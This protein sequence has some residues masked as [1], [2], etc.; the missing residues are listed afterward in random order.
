MKRD[1]NQRLAFVALIAAVGF[2]RA[3]VL[4]GAD[5][6]DYARDIKPLLVQHCAKCHGPA[7]REN[8][9]RLD[10][11][12]A[13]M[14]G[15]D[16]GAAIVPGKGTESLLVR[17]LLG[18]EENVSKMP[19]E[20]PGLSPEQIDLITRWIDAGANAPADEQPLPAPGSQHW[21]FQPPVRLAPPAV[22]NPAWPQNGVDSF[23]LTR[24]E[25][26][27]IAPSPEAERATLIRRV[28]LDLV[29]ILPTPT[30]VQEFT[31]DEHPDAYEA[32]VDRLLA[33]PHYGERWGRHWLDLARYADSNGYTRDFPRQIWKY[34]EWVIDAINRGQPFDEFTIEQIAGDMLPSP[35]TEQLVATG[36]HRNTLINEEGGTDQE[37]FRVEAVADRVATTGSVFLG[38][39]L[40]CA[41]CHTHKYDPI[42][43]VEYYELFALLNN[44]EEPSIEVPSRL[45]LARGELQQREAMRAKVKELEAQLEKQ[46]PEF[47]QAQVAWEKTITPQQRA[48]LPGPV[49]VAYDMAL[50]KRDEKNKKLIEDY[51]K[52][53][54][55][56][57]KAFPIVDE[58]YKL[59]QDEPKIPTTLILRELATPRET[60]VH[61]RGDFLDHGARVHGGVPAVLPALK[62]SSQ[63]EGGAGEKSTQP[64]SR[65][66]FARWLVSAEN[67]LTPRVVM[68]RDW[69][70]FF[71]RG[72]VETEDDFGVQGM[73]PSH[74]ELLD[75]LAKELSLGWDSK[76]MHRLLVNSATYRQ[77]SHIRS[78]LAQRD[79]QN[80]LLARQSRLRLEA[81][82]VRDV[83]L[84][85]AG[86]LCEVIG[87]PSV[88]PPQPDGVF[89]FT[90]DPKPWNPAS[91]GDRYR[92]G[93]YTQFLRSAP[94]P[95]LTVFDAPNAN[96]TCTRRIRSNTP[97]QALTVANDL[98]FVECAQAMG[99]RVVAA[100]LTG[101]S[102]ENID[103]RALLA[104]RLCVCREPTPAE[105]EHLL[106]LAR[107]ELEVYAKDLEGA[108][109]LLPASAA[110]ADAPRRMELAAWISLCRVLLN[111]D[112]TITRE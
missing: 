72:M 91:N 80:K 22:R 59:K 2:C 14:R 52:E 105:K 1:W 30:Q 74:P 42:S 106:A 54:E 76:R 103:E 4:K 38:L 95:S 62:T 26:E 101:T 99:E 55:E 28:Y 40:G 19:P 21:A 6:P 50:E 100:E 66:D 45:Q 63:G 32:L 69:Q 39:T 12:A 37:Q 82:I 79:P 86:L 85:A 77:S 68:N 64:A 44:C 17:A 34:R 83:A 5:A 24:L 90:Q 46:R 92:R 60:F 93:M 71:G 73:R 9:L 18:K 49:Q 51:F 78:D 57:R 53:T 75:F 89:D 111:L 109:E 112:E 15:G 94:Y 3:A 16:G 65:L 107:S 67:P 31:R 35:T 96:V 81:E 10:T 27:G 88:F 87:G 61:R 102:P 104:F 25:E 7:K 29:G 41:R 84:S 47:E 58:I 110:G 23:I 108:T 11:A 13:G 20:G 56:A 33:S 36:F 8:G 70:Q 98:A 43:Q 48:R 97:L